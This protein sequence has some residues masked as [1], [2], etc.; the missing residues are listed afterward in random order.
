MSC[1]GPGHLCV[2]RGC[3]LGTGHDCCEWHASGTAAESDVFAPG[4]D[5]FR[6]A[7]TVRPVLGDPPRRGQEPEGLAAAGTFIRLL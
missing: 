1:A 6:F 3:P 4:G 7:Q 2:V 5:G